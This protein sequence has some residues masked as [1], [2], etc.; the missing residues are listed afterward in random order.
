MHGHLVPDE[1]PELIYNYTKNQAGGFVPMRLE[2][3][4]AEM[5]QGVLVS[6]RHARMDA[7]QRCARGGFVKLVSNLARLSDCDYYTTVQAYGVQIGSYRDWPDEVLM[8]KLALALHAHGQEIPPPPAP[9]KRN[10][11]FHFRLEEH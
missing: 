10:G 9:T 6:Q 5:A 2:K 1:N 8:A 7:L 3:N 11:M 4:L